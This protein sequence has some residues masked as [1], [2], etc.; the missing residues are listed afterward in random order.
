M[1]CHPS[2]LAKDLV[3]KVLKIIMS[4][5]CYILKIG[6]NPLVCPQPWTVETVLFFPKIKYSNMSF[7]EQTTF[8][9]LNVT[10]I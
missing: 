10:H 6:Q 3:L 1:T 9:S 7:Y 8:A 2:E 5:I 4:G